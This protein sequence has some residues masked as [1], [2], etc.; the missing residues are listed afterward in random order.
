MLVNAGAD[1]AFKVFTDEFAD[2]V[3]T[4]APHRRGGRGGILV[5]FRQVFV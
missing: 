4:R 3:T 5:G 2:V 1:H